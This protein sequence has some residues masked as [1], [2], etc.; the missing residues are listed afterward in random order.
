MDIQ[1]ITRP[2]FAPVILGTSRQGRAREHVARGAFEGDPQPYS[3]SERELIAVSSN[4]FSQF[5]QI[6][7]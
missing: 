4:T 5:E 3:V 7:P 6:K 1:G 2:I